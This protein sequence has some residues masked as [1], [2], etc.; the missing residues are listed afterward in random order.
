MNEQPAPPTPQ[1]PPKGTTVSGDASPPLASDVPAAKGLNALPPGR[2]GTTADMRLTRMRLRYAVG[3]E[4]ALHLT[5]VLWRR[6]QF[7]RF[8]GPGARAGIAPLGAEMAELLA[9]LEDE[10]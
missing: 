8:G 3:A 9:H 7:L 2:A 4:M 5:D 6:T 1:A 10:E